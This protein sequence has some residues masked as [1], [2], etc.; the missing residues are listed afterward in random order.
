MAQRENYTDYSKKPSTY[1]LYCGPQSQSLECFARPRCR[2]HVV[3]LCF[4]FSSGSSITSG[5]KNLLS[6]ST[7]S[8][9]KV[10]QL[11]VETLLLGTQKFAQRDP[12]S[13][14]LSREVGGVHQ[15][16]ALKR[17]WEGKLIAPVKVVGESEDHA[18][19]ETRAP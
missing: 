19:W 10:V 15:S 11:S 18:R 17:R 7:P 2:S 6:H 5:L 1:V 8:V 13:S 12:K 14:E 9:S 16:S 4:S 3:L